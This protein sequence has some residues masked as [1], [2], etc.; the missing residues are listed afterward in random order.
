MPGGSIEVKKL[1]SVSYRMKSKIFKRLFFSYIFII[2]ICFSAYT[3]VVIHEALTLKREQTNQYYQMKLQEVTNL[4]DKQIMNAQSVIASINSSITINHLY[5]ETLTKKSVD[6]YL[7]VQVMNDLKSKKASSNNLNIYNVAVLFN[8]YNRTYTCGEIIYLEEAFEMLPKSDIRSQ[9]STLNQIISMNNPQL[10]FHK[11]FLIYNDDYRY[12]NGSRRGIVY[13]LFSKD[14]IQ[15]LLDK[16]LDEKISWT[17]YNNG[18]KLFSGGTGGSKSFMKKSTVNGEFTYEI[19]VDKGEFLL[20][21]DPIWVVALFVGFV[22]CICYIAFAYI[23]SSRYYKPFGLIRSLLSGRDDNE[24]MEFTDIITSVACLVSE[25]NGF[26]EK[27]LTI[28][29]YA[30][31]GIL[32]SILSG[33]LDSEHLKALCA[34]DITQLQHMYFMLAVINIGYV[35]KGTQDPEEI[36]GIKKSILQQSKVSTSKEMQVLCYEGDFQNIYIIINCDCGE[37]IEDLLYEFYNSIEAE[38]QKKDYVLTMGV[39]DVKEEVFQ[40]YES[41]KHAAMALYGMVIGGRG[42]VY[43][44][45]DKVTA[46]NDYYFPKDAIKIMTKAFREQ[47]MEELTQLFKDIYDKNMEEYDLSLTA[48]QSLLDELYIM[49]VNAV[50]II[51][52]MNSVKIKVDKLQSVTTLEEAINY[53]SKVCELVCHQ[54]ELTREE[55]IPNEKA[56][57]EIIKFVDENFKN[58]DICLSQITDKYHVSNKYITYLFKKQHGITYLQYVHEKRI[59]YSVE[60]L[61]M[62]N[63]SLDKVAEECGYTNLLTFRRN[64]KSIMGMNPSDYKENLN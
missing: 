16:I 4:M 36:K 53:Y 15:Y 21:Y 31:Q 58:R 19:M 44:Y 30:E 23:F 42:A 22:V 5:M 48:I 8:N 56:D 35:G 32:H 12:N 3:F 64:F 2:V 61:N 25:R 47:S 29:P 1:S 62:K 33:N 28:S 13:V 41:F 46:Q 17:V 37:K 45:E 20:S 54:T 60:L 24:E 52:P 55:I 57:F 51:N 50:K 43:F 26:K 6:P 14:N 63:D 18:N 27:V 10:L 11:E 7:I 40:L 9:F 34:D 49:T 39:D 59:E 38:N